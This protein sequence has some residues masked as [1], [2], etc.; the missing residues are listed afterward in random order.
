M[1]RRALRQ[2]EKR[3]LPSTLLQGGRA[4]PEALQQGRPRARRS[5]LRVQALRVTAAARCPGAPRLCRRSWSGWR[6][7]S[8]GGRGARRAPAGLPCLLL[9]KKGWSLQC[10]LPCDPLALAAAHCIYNAISLPHCMRHVT[11]L[12]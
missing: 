9:S 3:A 12:H 7:T 5:L 10:C 1:R 8:G 11:C 2:E 6:W 4:A